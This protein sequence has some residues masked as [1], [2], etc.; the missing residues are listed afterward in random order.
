M[1]HFLP[2]FFLVI[3]LATYLEAQEFYFPPALGEWESI[4]P[5]DLDWCDENLADLQNFL[6]E[7]DTK[8]FIILKNGRMVVEWYYDQFTQDSLWYWASAGKSLMATMIG[9]AQEEGL[10]DINDPTQDYLGNGWTSLSFEQEA[11][12]SIRHQ[13]TMTTGLNDINVEVD[14]TDPECLTYLAEPGTR[15]AYHNAPYTLVGDVLEAASGITPTQFFNNRIGFKIGGIGAYVPLGDNNIFFSTPRTMARFGHLILAGGQWGTTTVL[16]DLDYI[17]AMTTPS[18]EINPSYGYLWWLNGQESYMIP[19]LQFSF[20]GP[21]IPTA[22]AD[23]IAGLGKNDQKVYVVPSEG[24]VVV[25]MGNDASDALLALSDF[26]PLLWEKISNLACT[27]SSQAINPADDFLISPNPVREQLNIMT[28]EPFEVAHIFNLKGQR[29]LS[30]RTKSINTQMLT[31]GAYILSVKL[32][33]GKVIR[34]RFI[35]GK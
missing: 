16:G 7:R 19:R 31:E 17:T 29:M 23:M 25:R 14:C 22:P 18:Q 27:T 30:T 20:P 1:K 4:P 15:W 26:D 5:S 2:L 6:G 8:A 24:L 11:A 35:V 33:S 9:I 32:S 12:I 3:N 34:K 13:L 28:D 21:I 10:L